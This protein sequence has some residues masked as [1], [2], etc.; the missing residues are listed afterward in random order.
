MTTEHIKPE[1]KDIDGLPEDVVASYIRAASQLI[2][3]V[4]TNVK[5][6]NIIRSWNSLGLLDP[7]RDASTARLAHLINMSNWFLG[8]RST[9]VAV[10]SP[11]TS[12]ESAP[13]NDYFY[14]ENSDCPTRPGGKAQKDV[15]SVVAPPSYSLIGRE[16]GP[17]ET[18]KGPD[19][20]FSK[21]WMM[22]IAFNGGY[23]LAK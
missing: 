3:L 6:V 21:D 2:E 4:N 5:E 17:E 16:A 18:S 11:G 9:I 23:K 10:A 15:S 13:T 7:A 8:V 12:G 1:F 20:D 22:H 19:D 14:A